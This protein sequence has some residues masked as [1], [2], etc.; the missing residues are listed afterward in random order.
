MPHLEEVIE[1][2]FAGDECRGEADDRPESV[3]H[4][5]TL[6]AQAAGSQRAKQFLDIIINIII[7]III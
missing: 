4:V 3:L 1:A 5:V 6:R 7:I 2:Q